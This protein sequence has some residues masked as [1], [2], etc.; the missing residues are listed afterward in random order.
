MTDVETCASCGAEVN[1]HEAQAVRT[2]L[3][4]ATISQLGVF[5]ELFGGQPPALLDAVCFNAALGNVNARLVPQTNP[6]T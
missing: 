4:H 6:P 3:E 2:A 5:A 1:P